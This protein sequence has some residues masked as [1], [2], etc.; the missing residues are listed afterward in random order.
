MA[1]AKRL[2]DITIEGIPDSIVSVKS[3]SITTTFSN[4][5]HNSK[6]QQPKKQQAPARHGINPQSPIVYVSPEMKRLLKLLKAHILINESESISESAIIAKALKEYCKIKQT[7]FYNNNKPL[8][9]SL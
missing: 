3:S 6:K 8:F 9:E 2:E 4:S 5:T 7:E 1:K